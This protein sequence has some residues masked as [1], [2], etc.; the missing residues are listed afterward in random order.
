MSGFCVDDEFHKAAEY[1]GRPIYK[2]SEFLKACSRE[3]YVLFLPLSARDRCQFRKRKFMQFEQLGYDFFTFVSKG[4]HV[5]T[6]RRNL[7]RNVYIGCSA[8]LHPD[9]KVNDNC[10]LAERSGIGH[11]CCIGRDSF[12]G[13]GAIL[14]GNCTIG[15]G[16]S[17]GAASVLRENLRV[18]AGSVI[19]MGI[20][21]HRDIEKAGIYL[22]SPLEDEHFVHSKQSNL[23]GSGL[24]Q[25]KR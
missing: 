7:G 8:I 6:D 15:E 9:V 19:G 14:C 5:Y 4:A 1:S 24:E 21:V 11:D 20:S 10:F 13:P 25:N 18:A 12:I 22:F 17:I 23:T 3:E 16:V 2:T